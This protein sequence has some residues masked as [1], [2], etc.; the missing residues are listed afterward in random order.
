MKY[1][2]VHFNFRHTT[3]QRACI[4]KYGIIMKGEIFDSAT[5]KRKRAKTVQRNEG[6]NEKKRSE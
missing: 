1:T 2:F 4:R 5:F 6:I 3:E